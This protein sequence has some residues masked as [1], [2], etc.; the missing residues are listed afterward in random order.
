M[1]IGDVSDISA[2]DTLGR[3]LKDL[4]IMVSGH[5]RN[6]PTFPLNPNR[7]NSSDFRD[8]LVLEW[9]GR[10]GFPL[11]LFLPRNLRPERVRPVL[12]PRFLPLL[13]R[14]FRGRL[15]LLRLTLF[16]PRNLRPERVRPVLGPRFTPLLLLVFLPPII[17]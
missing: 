4:R 9:T 16:L 13:L 17:L 3:L 6:A 14:T 1:V 7:A 11:T 12:G 5:F 10:C 2:I 15:T 8:C